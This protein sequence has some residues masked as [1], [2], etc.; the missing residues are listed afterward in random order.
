MLKLKNC[1]NLLKVWWFKASGKIKRHIDLVD[2]TRCNFK[3][4][5]VV[6]RRESGKEKMIY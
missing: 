2:E 3:T 4:T 1:D 5:V 6:K